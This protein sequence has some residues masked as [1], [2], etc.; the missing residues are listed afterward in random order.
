MRMILDN[1]QNYSKEA[2]SL[3]Q[4]VLGWLETMHLSEAPGCTY[5]LNAG[6]DPSVFASCFA[7]FL[8]H[9]FADLDRLTENERSN[10]LI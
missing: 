4:N 1:T 2:L 8:R 10:W 5:K 9:L 7:V 3:R 6:A